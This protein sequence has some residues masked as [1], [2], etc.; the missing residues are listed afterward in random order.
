MSK[1]TF[2]ARSW[3][4]ETHEVP[5]L[6]E[7][8]IRDHLRRGDYDPVIRSHIHLVMWVVTRLHVPDHGWDDAVAAGALGLTEAARKFDLDRGAKFRTYAIHRIRGSVLD[9]GFTVRTPVSIGRSGNGMAAFWRIIRFPDESDEEVAAA[10]K[11]TVRI[12]AQVRG[13][14]GPPVLLDAPAGSS[15]DGDEMAARV[16]A[17]PHPTASADAGLMVREHQDNLREALDQILAVART[18]R[19][20]DVLM[21]RILSPDHYVLKDIGDRWGICRE[22]V[23]QIE[24]N[25]RR[26]LAEAG[27]THLGQTR[28]AQRK[29][30]R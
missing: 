6:S 19:E 29:A 8:E 10:I 20:R 1:S 17:F 18:D 12:V 27:Y 22:R 26:R 24:R 3:R 16:E 14:L 2:T 4:P 23:R 13:A 21:G 11:S 5:R 28:A 9:A 15:P 25:L 7:N 30:A